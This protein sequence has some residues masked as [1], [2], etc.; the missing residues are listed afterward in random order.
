MW[1][2]FLNGEIVINVR[3]L[4]EYREV[5]EKAKRFGLN[6]IRY[7]ESRYEIYKSNTC[8][9]VENG[10]LFYSS[11]KFYEENNYK[12][13]NY[14]N[15]KD[16]ITK[17]EIVNM[18]ELLT[19]Y[20]NENVSLDDFDYITAINLDNHFIDKVVN[21]DLDVVLEMIQDDNVVFVK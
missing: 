4:E 19:E 16:I 20:I 12:V 3:N 1:K 6:V 11:R 10:S 18:K 15:N 13:I 2:M 21:L 5:I 17:H 9:C 14:R 8:L 7:D